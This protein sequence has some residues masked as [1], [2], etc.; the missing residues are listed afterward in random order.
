MKFEQTSQYL[1][2]GQTKE[3]YRQLTVFTLPL[4][5]GRSHLKTKAMVTKSN[6][7]L[8]GQGAPETPGRT[9]APGKVV[10]TSGAGDPPGEALKPPTCHSFISC[11]DV[12][13]R[14]TR[15]RPRKGAQGK[16]VSK[17]DVGWEHPS[18]KNL[19]DHNPSPAAVSPP[20]LQGAATATTAAAAVNQLTPASTAV[21]FAATVAKMRGREMLNVSIHAWPRLTPWR[22]DRGE[23]VNCGQGVHGYHFGYGKCSLGSLLASNARA[24]RTKMEESMKWG[25][26]EEEE[27]NSATR[28]EEV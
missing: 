24:G 21:T 20:R 23:G 16:N 10:G 26:T 2:Q 5:A 17:K 13:C 1:R 3:E 19:W 12:V 28:L 14:T 4:R 11:R 6:C 9:Y 18:G 15:G 7:H 22:R 25:Q 8:P 27:K